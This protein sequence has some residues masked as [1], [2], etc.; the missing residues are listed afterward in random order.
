V[1]GYIA[2]SGGKKDTGKRL[3]FSRVSITVRKK[4]GPHGGERQ[5]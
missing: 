3:F 4:D 5:E 2:D 1:T